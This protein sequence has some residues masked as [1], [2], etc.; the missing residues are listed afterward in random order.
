MLSRL[1]LIWHHCTTAFLDGMIAQELLS[2]N[3]VLTQE[4]VIAAASTTIPKFILDQKEGIHL[5][6]DSE[7]PQRTLS[8][9]LF[10]AMPSEKKKTK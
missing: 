10:S 9:L 4:Y 1:Y 5:R 8:A 6:K 3:M 7:R 2:A